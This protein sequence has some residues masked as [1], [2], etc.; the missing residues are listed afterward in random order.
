MK[1]I[2]P[3]DDMT[4]TMRIDLHS[5]SVD[6]P[7]I[8]EVKMSLLNKSKVRAKSRI[9]H[10]G[11][12]RFSPE[13][14]KLL[15][16]IY[17]AVIITDSGGSVID[18][19]T[20]ALEFFRCGDK[21]IRGTNIIDRISGSDFTL[22][23]GIWQNLKDQ[24][25]TMIEGNCVREDESLFPA[26]IAVNKIELD[27]KESLCFFVRNIAI[28]KQAQAALE[29][30]VARLEEQDRSRSQ[31][32]ANV[33]HELRTPLTSMIYGIANLIKGV[34]GPV[35]DKLMRY[36]ETLDRDCKRLLGTVND[37]LDLRKIEAKTLVLTKAKIPFSRLVHRTVESLRVQ[38]EQK[39]LTLKVSTGTE[40][41]FVE[42][43]FHKMERVILNIM[44]NAIK[45]TPRDG[46]I[47]VVAGIDP[48]NAD[49]VFVSIQDTGIGIPPEAI[50]R[51][52]ERYFTVGEQPSG[53]G[54]GLAI[55]KEIVELHGGRIRVQS[56]PPGVDKGT[57][58]SFTIPADKQVPTVLIVDDEPAI[59][60]L[61]EYQI[62]SYGYKIIRAGNGTEALDK[63]E[64]NRPDI[65]VLDLVLPETEGTEVILKM[66][67]NK[68]T[69]KVPII[70]IT[71]AHVGHAKAQILDNFSIPAMSK[72]WQEEELM[73]RIEGAF[74]GVATLGH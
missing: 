23:E 48:E 26:E 25:Y 56:P 64:K 53:S 39:S 14:K 57:M 38:A 54:L 10:K 70:V 30:A 35:S 22:L 73:D 61:L 62:A 18:C 69:R 49:D 40:R 59:L 63:V 17:D 71:G 72:P 33:S 27:G 24:R 42:C 44:G 68:A 55:S 67:S 60:D 20:R 32:V 7:D 36:L 41:R 43:D 46:V 12:D 50:D 1:Q 31:F 52:T 66:K 74:I 5:V 2:P 9:Q 34:A 8:E 16:S 28:R 58:I 37:I 21:D 6:T 13:Y 65:V 45:F 29:D 15:E 19:N 4:K 3:K 47:N 11:R 51:V